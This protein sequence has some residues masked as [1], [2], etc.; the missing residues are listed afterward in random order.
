M[1]MLSFVKGALIDTCLFVGVGIEARNF[2]LKAIMNKPGGAVDSIGSY[3]EEEKEPIIFD[4]QG[5]EIALK[6]AGVTEEQT[7][8]YLVIGNYYFEYEGVPIT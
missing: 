5:L 3:F 1:I 6:H 4:D 2:K 7:D 8:D